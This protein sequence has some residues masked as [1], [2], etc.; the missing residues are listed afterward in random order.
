MFL[1][2]YVMLMHKKVDD[3]LCNIM[4]QGLIGLTSYNFF[5]LKTHLQRTLRLSVL[6]LE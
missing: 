3:N 4:A 6:G 1:S 2:F 5:F